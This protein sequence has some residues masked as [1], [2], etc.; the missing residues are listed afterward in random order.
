MK[1]RTVMIMLL[2]LLYA[3]IVYLILNPQIYEYYVD[4][5][6]FNNRVFSRGDERAFANK[7]PQKSIN[8]FTAYQF[9]KEQPEIMTLG[10]GNPKS[11]GCWS[12]GNLAKIAFA[13]PQTN[14]DTSVTLRVSAYVN[15]KNKKITVVPIINNKEYAAWDFQNGK[16]DQKTTLLIPQ[17]LVPPDKKIEIAFKI[18]GYKSPQELGYGNDKNKLGIFI[19]EIAFAPKFKS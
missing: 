1:L 10:F 13:L 17:K 2:S 7:N 4:Y 14:A 8:F 18:K 19:S 12:H 15:T 9:N 3:D 11:D 16:N 5:Y 6:F